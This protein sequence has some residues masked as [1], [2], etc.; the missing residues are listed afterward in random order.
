MPKRVVNYSNRPR[1]K[2]TRRPFT[3]DHADVHYP[4]YGA[5]Q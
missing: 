3:A 4:I 2:I 1:I 5:A